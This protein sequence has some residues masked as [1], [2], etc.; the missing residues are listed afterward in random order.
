MKGNNTQNR[1]IQAEQ[2]AYEVHAEL[3]S[4]LPPEL[5]NNINWE[6]V[7][8]DLR[9]EPGIL[10]P[11]EIVDALAELFN[12]LKAIGFFDSINR[13]WDERWCKA[14]DT[15]ELVD[16]WIRSLNRPA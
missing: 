14:Y 8:E 16:H 4:K 11:L 13:G 1:K 10:V 2:W 12:D 3:M 15:A 5:R 6:A 7:A 9:S